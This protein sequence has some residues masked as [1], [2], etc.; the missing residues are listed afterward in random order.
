VRAE[1]T[2]PGEPCAIAGVVVDVEGVGKDFSGPYYIERA[3][4][5]FLQQGFSTTLHLLRTAT[6]LSDKPL[7]L[8]PDRPPRVRPPQPKPVPGG[9]VL[10]PWDD[11]GDWKPDLANLQFGYRMK[12]ELLNLKLWY[13]TKKQREQMGVALDG[14]GIKMH[15]FAADGLG[16]ADMEN[17]KPR[18][19]NVKLAYQDANGKLAGGAPPAPGNIH[20]PGGGAAPGVIP[21]G[22]GAIPGGGP[23]PPQD[24]LIDGGGPAP[25]MKPKLANVKLNYAKGN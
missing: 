2:L 10:T 24:H 12:P 15:G 9:G 7:K 21:L 6:G 13:M 11:G 14:G 16:V 1:A 4:H 8:T 5:S 3:I 23:K 22:P 17:L 18:L 19:A 20:I 25:M